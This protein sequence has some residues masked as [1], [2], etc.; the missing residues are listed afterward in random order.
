[1]ID[2]YWGLQVTI[3]KKCYISLMKID[4]VLTSNADPDE[5]SPSA[6]YIMVFTTCH[7]THLGVSRT[8]PA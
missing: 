7:S 6:A 3:S 1:M 2:R 8:L 5:M 4:F